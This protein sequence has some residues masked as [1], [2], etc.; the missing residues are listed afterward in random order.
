M[1]KKNTYLQILER[2]INFTSH[3]AVL[4]FYAQNIFSLSSLCVPFSRVINNVWLWWLAVFHVFFLFLCSSLPLFL[5]RKSP[6]RAF[7]YK[8][9][10]LWRWAKNVVL[11]SMPWN[12]CKTETCYMMKLHTHTHALLF[13]YHWND[14][15]KVLIWKSMAWQRTAT[16]AFNLRFVSKH[17]KWIGQKQFA[18]SSIKSHG[19]LSLWRLHLLCQYIHLTFDVSVGEKHSGYPEHAHTNASNCI[20][21]S[22]KSTQ[23]LFKLKLMCK[24]CREQKL[25]RFHCQ[26]CW[27]VRNMKTFWFC[28]IEFHSNQLFDFMLQLF[29]HRKRKYDGGSIYINVFSR[30]GHT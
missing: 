14:E 9:T 6:E 21:H 3:F 26:K 1:Q 12:W 30:M 15:K 17:R 28:A 20:L 29:I 10:F 25:N 7:D 2:Y 5:Y 22:M 13:H 8:N 23:S 4:Y 27:I 24:C 19:K 11:F 16:E 18:N